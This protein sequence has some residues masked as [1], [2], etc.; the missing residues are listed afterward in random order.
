M[1]VEGASSEE[2]PARVVTLAPFFLDRTEVTVSAYAECVNASRCKEPPE[3]RPKTE[4]GKCN[5]GTQEEFGDHPINCVD[6]DQASAYCAFAGKRLPTQEEWEYAARG[7]DGRL[8]PW[9]TAAPTDQLCWKRNEVGLA[10]CAVGSA[11]GDVSPAGAMDMAGN[12]VEWTVGATCFSSLGEMEKKVPTGRWVR[13]GDWFDYKP[14]DVDATYRTC[15]DP[16][17]RNSTVGFRCAKS[18]SEK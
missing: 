17:I 15:L 9:G 8:F 16:A 12:V 2:P 6:F 10:S 5:W 14:K 11:S 13:G 1:G 18:A 4:L 7:S 3:R